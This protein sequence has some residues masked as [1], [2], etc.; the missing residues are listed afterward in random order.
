[1][2]KPTV[3]GIVMTNSMSTSTVEKALRRLGEV[4]VYHCDIEILIVGGAAGMVTGVLPATQTTMDCDVMVYDPPEA[5]TA[6]ESAADEV[7]TELALASDWLNSNVQMR[8]D[9]LPAGWE[10]RRISVGSYGRLRVWA[11]SRP[12]L[13]AMKVLAGRDQ[14]IEDLQAMRI[15]PDDVQFVHEYLDALADKG[16]Q[17]E[18]IDDARGLLASLEVHDHE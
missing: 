15:R 9:A 11:A 3:S 6:V 2:I 7:A 4:L 10:Q 12:D 5:M 18:Q 14:D 17:Q 16:T 13:I 8:L 1:M